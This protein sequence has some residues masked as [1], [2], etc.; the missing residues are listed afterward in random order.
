MSAELEHEGLKATV[1]LISPLQNVKLFLFKNTPISRT[2]QV[3]PLWLLNGFMYRMISDADTHFRHCDM[4]DTMCIPYL[5]V[6]SQS[7]FASAVCTGTPADSDTFHFP[8]NENILNF[9]LASDPVMVK[10][11]SVQ[12][13]CLQYSMTFA[14]NPIMTLPWTNDLCKESHHD[15]TLN[16]VL[17]V[18]ILLLPPLMIWLLRS[19]TWLSALETS[20]V[21]CCRRDI[22]LSWTAIKDTK[23]Q[24]FCKHKQLWSHPS[25]LPDSHVYSTC[26]F[27]IYLCPSDPKSTSLFWFMSVSARPL[28]VPG[29]R[30]PCTCRPIARGSQWVRQPFPRWLEVQILQETSINCNGE[31][32]PPEGPFL[33]FSFK[34]IQA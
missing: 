7:S 5:H 20:E 11:I 33:I 12:C 23:S 26:G 31:M 29:L 25:N 16:C 15:L 22:L 8:A 28:Q 14:R 21:S 18:P 3:H 4:R 30:Y 34:A 27:T 2:C 6:Q 1:N 19:E 24:C 9:T 32:E 17:D 13:Q 10:H